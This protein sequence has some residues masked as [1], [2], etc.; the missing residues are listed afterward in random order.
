MISLTNI[1]LAFD[2]IL[3]EDG[4]LSIFNGQITG[5]IGDSGCGKTTLLQKI[6]LLS[7]IE[8]INYI[9]HGRNLNSLSSREMNDFLRNHISF[10]L[11]DI[12]M[13]DSLTIEE[14]INI[15]AKMINKDI[16]KDDIYSYLD[17]VNLSLDIS[18]P[19]DTMSGG[20]KQRLAI[21]CGLIKD[22]QLFIFDE[23]TAYLDTKN[24][25]NILKIIRKLAKEEN[26]AVLIASHDRTLIQECHR[27][28]EMKSQNLILTKNE[29]IDERITNLLE[30]KF[31]FAVLKQLINYQAKYHIVKK[32]LMISIFTLLMIITV[33]F[34]SFYDNY[35]KNNE[36]SLLG[37]MRNVI[38]IGLESGSNLRPRQQADLKN[39]LVDFDVYSNYSEKLIVDS[40]QNVHIYSYVPIEEKSFH[41][42]QKIQDESFFLQN[43]V[44]PIYMS[45]S[46]YRKIGQNKLHNL[47]D[48]AENNC[49]FMC[50]YVLKP[51]DDNEDALYL[52]YDVFR[53]YLISI[54][55]NIDLQKT[56]NVKVVVEKL[57]DIS[58]IEK[59]IHEPFKIFYPENI[60]K[61]IK[62][63]QIFENQS[64]TIFIII[65]WSMYLVYKIIEIFK[66]RK[67]I[68]LLKMLGVRSQEIMKMRLY[69][70]GHVILVSEI[71]AIALSIILLKFFGII[72]F[73]AILES[74]MGL[75]MIGM[76]IYILLMI[77][78]FVYINCNSSAK[79]LRI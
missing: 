31:D 26:K 25:E 13:F 46:L 56:E 77:V 4:E 52:S 39:E 61:Q 7:S 63:A 38:Y 66:L 60:G 44:K 27:I 1:N 54:D 47:N 11:Q 57:S 49:E 2:K 3:L 71:I 18:T 34:G 32:Y 42:Y 10:V 35:Q 20:E 76:C 79:L 15:H 78:S 75:C 74:I 9:F 50:S 24:K 5:I 12:Y 22:A 17:Y 33:V 72:T 64:L 59:Q 62:I 69:E 23:P 41:I 73:K 19:V 28:Y 58:R 70:E 16:A 6:G 30:N 68:A 36:Q 14:V 48:Y 53:E 51:S 65:T 67:D 45:Y 40:I 43:Q 37:I 29:I 55:R 21:I 8:D